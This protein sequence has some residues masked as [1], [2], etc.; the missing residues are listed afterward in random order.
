MGGCYYPR[1]LDNSTPKPFL[2]SS[3]IERDCPVLVFDFPSGIV[4]SD[5]SS[6]LFH[7]IHQS[8]VYWGKPLALCLMVGESITI[9]E[10]RSVNTSW[11]IGSVT[12]KVESSPRNIHRRRSST[13]STNSDRRERQTFQS[14]SAVTGGL[15][16]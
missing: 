5:I 15:L 14:T 4:P 2:V 13:L 3:W 8:I 9:C 10:A 6:D 11:R 1:L 7:Y 12:K 16:T